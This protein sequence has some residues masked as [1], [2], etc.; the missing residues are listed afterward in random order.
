MTLA[1]ERSA[2]GVSRAGRGVNSTRRALTTAGHR[3]RAIALFTIPFLALFVLTNV[4]PLLFAIGQSFFA[5]K[6]SGL[7]LTAPETV[8][9]GVDN[10]ARVVT[11]PDF[12]GSFGHMFGIAIVQVPVMLGGALVL[13]LLLDSA[14]ARGVRAFRLIYFLP[15]AIPGLV[16]AILWSYLYSP[17][18]SPIVDAAANVGVDL[19]FLAQG[20]VLLSIGNMITWGWMG[21]NMLII[22]SA[23]QSIPRE[24]YEA[25]RLDGASEWQLALRIKLPQVGPALVL[26]GTLSIIGA[27]QIFNEAKVLET[28]SDN[29]NSTFV[30]TM[31]VMQAAFQSDD[32]NYAAAASVVVAII[33]GVLSMLYY[34][35][36]TR[37]AQ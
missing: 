19:D 13:A 11:D 37:K 9:V 7:G 23:L 30:P 34:R 15:Y 36:T 18:L 17:T 22:L 6:S 10:Y 20:T 5:R 26:T 27:I 21:Y 31:F 33:A 8:F 16:G 28:I 35:L 24:M 29:V 4:A 1:T 32:F 2:S 12:W 25:A 3:R 14:A